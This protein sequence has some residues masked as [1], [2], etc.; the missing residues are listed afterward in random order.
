[1][2]KLN[3]VIKIE[4]LPSEGKEALLKKYP[5]GW[6][7]F[8]RKITKPSGEFFYAINVDTEMVSYL[9]K[10][11]VKVDSKSDLEKM[12]RKFYNTDD[13]KDE[14]KATEH[15]TLDNVDVADT[16]ED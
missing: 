14:D 4:D 9:V 12:E 7:D 11:N 5:N 13:D 16:T 1:M 10:V 8:V 2:D 15:E 3:K 6:R